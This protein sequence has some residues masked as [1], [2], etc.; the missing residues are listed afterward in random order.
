MADTSVTS[1]LVTGHIVAPT[2]ATD[3]RLSI[4]RAKLI[5]I[6]LTTA[7]TVLSSN[8]LFEDW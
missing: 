6:V 2:I 8:N 1:D 5:K 4:K 7:F 3:A